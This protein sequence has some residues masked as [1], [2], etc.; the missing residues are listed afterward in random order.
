MMSRWFV[1]AAALL[2]VGCNALTGTT[3]IGNSLVYEAPVTF[4]VTAGSLLNGTSIAYQGKTDTG[5]AKV[6]LAGIPA[7]KQTA[8]SVDW[9]GNL[10]SNVAVVLKTRVAKYDDKSVTLAGTAR[11]Q[12]SGV[13]IKPGGTPPTTALME[14]IVPVVTY[15]LSK[16]QIIPGTNISFLGSAA[17]GAQFGGVEGYPYRKQFDSVQYVGRLAPKVFLQL[18]LRVL[19][20]SDTAATLAGPARIW[21][22]NP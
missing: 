21:V 3:A 12:I 6:M 14:F 22:E 5:S 13:D 11:L 20:S 19:N 8:D 4:E 17:D 1:L 18:D 2:L 10:V 7:P 15:T 9:N 16:S